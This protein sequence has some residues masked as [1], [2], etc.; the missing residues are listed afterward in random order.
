MP[1]LT[2]HLFVLLLYVIWKLHL[3]L[4]DTASVFEESHL[5]CFE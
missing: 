2:A 3:C 4:D 1:R 5:L